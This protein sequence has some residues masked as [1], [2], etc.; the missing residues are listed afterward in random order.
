MNDPRGRRHPDALGRLVEDYSYPFQKRHHVAR[1]RSGVYPHR[2]DPVHE[3]SEFLPG[4]F[5]GTNENASTKLKL[6]MECCCF[7]GIEYGRDFRAT[8]LELKAGELRQRLEFRF[9]LWRRL[10]LDPIWT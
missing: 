9:N 8:G 2:P 4:Y 1:D 3:V 6:L 5:V 7:A 10:G